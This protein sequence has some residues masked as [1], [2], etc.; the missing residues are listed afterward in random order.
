MH[1]F[2]PPHDAIRVQDAID[3]S[4]PPGRVAALY[5]EVEKWGATF[6]ATIERAE[7]TETGS[8]WKHILVTHR[9]EGRVPNTLTFL[10]DTEIGLEESKKR[11]DACFLN[12]FNPGS[13][14]GTH[15]VITAYIRLNGIYKALR[16]FI[17]GVVRW[18]AHNQMKRYV[19][20][21]LKTAAEKE[22]L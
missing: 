9:M 2:A 19:L 7:A 1:D 14:G 13:N 4:A 20:D 8:N 22:H 12:Q 21:P 15:Y 5:C 18:R 3:I 11:F 17:K 10:S 6:P 16:P